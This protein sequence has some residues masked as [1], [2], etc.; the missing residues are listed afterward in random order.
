MEPLP[1]TIAAQYPF[2]PHFYETLWGPMHYVDEG[3]GPAVVLLHGNPAWSF[4]YRDLITALRGRFRCIAPD[5]IGCGRSAKPQTGFNYTLAEH[6]DNV[7]GLVEHHL[8]LKRFHLVVHDWGGPV[9][10]ALA[11]RFPERIDRIQILNTAAFRMR[12][13][14]W[15]IAACKVPVI[16]EWLAR[17][18]NAF[19]WGATR[20]CTRKP[21]PPEVRAGYLWPYQ[22]WASRI[23]VHR[24]VRDIPRSPSHRSYRTLAMIED[25]LHRIAG[26]PMHICWGLGDWCFGKTFLN[27]WRRRFPAATVREFPETAHYLIEDETEAVIAAIAAFLGGKTPP[28]NS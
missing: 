28:G 12:E 6:I 7:V 17:G 25:N 11:E 5:H 3:T 27:E 15:Q 13:L 23:A 24:F 10:M 20:F 21:M 26:R 18:L 9:G 14:P 2:A 4:M 19:C 16:G 8:E 1:D 22:D